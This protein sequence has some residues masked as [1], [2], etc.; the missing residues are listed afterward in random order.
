LQKKPVYLEYGDREIA[1]LTEAD[2]KL[3]AYIARIGK[4]MRPVEPDGFVALTDCMISQQ[5]SGKAA[6][7]IAGRLRER[8]GEMTPAALLELDGEGYR[9]CG[10]SARK[11][12]Y[13]RGAAEAV[14]SGRLDF[15]A[16]SALEDEEVVRCLTALPGVGVWTAQM[17]LIFSLQR[18]DILS[19]GDF[20]IRRGL[21][22][23]HGEQAVQREA[24]ERYRRLYSPYGTVASL[25]LWEIARLED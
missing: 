17:L 10:I 24:F 23:L 3:G 9:S 7:T 21:T 12:G 15:S 19:F 22:R 20:G 11:A 2:G 16:L 4:L 1:H 6:A 14:M 18:R 5:I 25:Y 8:V 13:L